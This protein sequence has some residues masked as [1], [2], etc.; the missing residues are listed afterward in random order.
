MSHID[1]RIFYDDGQIKIPSNHYYIYFD[2]SS[3][4]KV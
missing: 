2:K 1:Q 3:S 4:G